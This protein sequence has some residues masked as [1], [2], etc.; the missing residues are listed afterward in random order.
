MKEMA[1]PAIHLGNSRIP[2]EMEAQNER[3]EANIEISA[4]PGKLT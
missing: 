2:G 3:G 4:S 1:D